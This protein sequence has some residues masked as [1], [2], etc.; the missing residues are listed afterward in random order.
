MKLKLKLNATE[1][2][3][4]NQYLFGSIS[5][6]PIEELKR[7]PFDLLIASAL[8][9]LYQKTSAKCEDIRT[10]PRKT[11]QV[12]AISLTR[13]QCLAIVCSLPEDQNKGETYETSFIKRMVGIIHQNFLV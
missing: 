2:A 1:L 7:N 3:T 5:C 9:E 6:Q 12:Y 8:W 10:F 13:S 4:L 11:D